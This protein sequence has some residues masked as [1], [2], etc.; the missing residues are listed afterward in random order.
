VGVS[1]GRSGIA[2]TIFG[3]TIDDLVRDPGQPVM[4]INGVDVDED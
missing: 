3:S 1:N 2:R 4:V